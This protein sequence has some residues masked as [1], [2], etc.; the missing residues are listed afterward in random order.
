[1][2]LDALIA[3]DEDLLRQSLVAQL[4]RLWPELRLVAECE[5]GASALERLAELKPD[6]AL[7]DIRMPG[8]SGIDVARALPELS[9]RTQVVF[10]TAYDQYAIDAFEQGAIDYLLKPVSDERL[11]A[12]R[13]RI[14]ARMQMG[15]PDNAVLEQ[16]LQRLGQQPAAHSTAPPLAW[17]TASNGRDT[18]LI[19]LE[20]VVYFRADSKYTTVVTEAG[21]SLLRTPLR[22]LLEVLDPQRFRQVHRSTIVNMKAVAAVTRDD[23]GRGQLRL[24]QRPE[25][26]NVSQPFM[27]LFR[28][29]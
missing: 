16:L 4:Q 24:K 28:G 25:L 10:V 22:E 9:P 3:E 18:Q 26:L 20:D 2:Q 5:D 27:S 21:E 11:L 7:L 23:T 17:I 8:I 13:E 1:M 12:T 14:L 19:M 29:M 15:R 6:L